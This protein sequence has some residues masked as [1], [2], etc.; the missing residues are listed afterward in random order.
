MTDAPD[1]DGTVQFRPRP[2]S[3]E[4]RLAGFSLLRRLLIYHLALAAVLAV[5]LVLVPALPA[6]LPIGG[7]KVLAEGTDLT[8]P[9]LPI[10]PG[11]GNLDHARQLVLTLAGIWLLML[12]VSWVH[13][14]IHRSSTFDHS[15][16]KTTMILP[17]VVA[18][19][20]LVVQ[21]SLALAFA[22]AGVVAGVQF[23]R[24]LQ[25]TFDALFILMAIGT[26]IAAGVEALEVAAVM[27]VFFCYATLYVCRF[28]D[29]FESDYMAEHK[30]RKRLLKARQHPA[31]AGPDTEPP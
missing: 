25:N 27:T 26:G 3:P 5:L 18:S 17:G 6:Y 24:A 19:I 22:L 9:E 12:P 8:A 21:Y 15:L 20:V 29:G 13:R 23:R 10:L 28:G 7:V 16:D 31:D 11:P 2:G 14:G 1:I 30:E 4:A